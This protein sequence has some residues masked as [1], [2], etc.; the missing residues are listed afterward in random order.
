MLRV[1]ATPMW[2]LSSERLS[3]LV[4]DTEQWIRRTRVWIQL[5]LTPGSH[6]L[7]CV[8]LAK[9]RVWGGLCSSMGS[10]PSLEN[11][12]KDP[13]LLQLWCRL[14]LWLIFNPWPGYFHMP[15]AQLKKNTKGS[16]SFK[17]ESLRVILG[18]FLPRR[19]R[20]KRYI[21]YLCLCI[22]LHNSVK[23]VTCCGYQSIGCRCWWF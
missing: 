19:R 14:Q 11:C 21:K 4:K 1:I 12:I 18:L 10:I 22:T 3:N 16:L 15:R 23:T 17:T 8:T 13:D 2:K 5:C 6:Y 7:Y 20:R 9:R